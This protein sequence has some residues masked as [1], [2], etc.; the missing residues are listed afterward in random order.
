[1]HNFP[2]EVLLDV[3]EKLEKKLTVSVK[4]VCIQSFYV[5]VMFHMRFLST[6]V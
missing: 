2:R 6:L 5:F 3:T 4:K 1:M